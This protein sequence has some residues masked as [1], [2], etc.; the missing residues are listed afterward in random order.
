MNLLETIL[1]AQGGGAVRG[2]AQNFG[3]DERQATA[4]I[5]QFLPALSSG[6]KRNV[7]SEGGLQALLGA[8]EKGSHDQYL[9]QPERLT[10]P[11]TV[12]D[13]NA[14]LGHLLGGKDV[15][16]QVAGNAAASTGLPVDLL[17]Q[18]LPIV[19]TMAMGALSK[20]T[21]QQG[22]Q[23]R[24]A[25]QQPANDLLGMLTPMLDADGDG[26]VADDLLGMAA[27]FFS[28]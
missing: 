11:E 19:A 10:R 24:A 23:S 5:Q 21:A 12:S 22:I 1:E 14:I 13:G 15:S 8:L 7:G 16:R 3:I 4:A 26:S 18:M 27:K 28:R 17:K 2:L 9:Q 6:L 20:N 25:A